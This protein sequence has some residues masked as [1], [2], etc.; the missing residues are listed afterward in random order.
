MQPHSLYMCIMVNF[1]HL[2]NLATMSMCQCLTRPCNTTASVRSRPTCME[3]SSCCLCARLGSSR[4]GWLPPGRP[5]DT[6]SF[7]CAR[8][9]LQEWRAWPWNTGRL[10][11]DRDILA[12]VSPDMVQQWWVVVCKLGVISRISHACAHLNGMIALESVCGPAAR[13]PVGFVLAHPR[14][15][16]ERHVRQTWC[17]HH[18]PL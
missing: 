6:S 5:C 9:P 4:C 8:S 3:N 11:A 10:V 2:K 7:R 12:R 14:G 16:H 15:G 17:A 1:Q 18:I 13:E